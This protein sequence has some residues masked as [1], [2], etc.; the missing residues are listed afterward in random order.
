VIKFG[1]IKNFRIFTFQITFQITFILNHGI[2]ITR[3]FMMN[4][5]I[6]LSFAIYVIL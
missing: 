2:K 3:T 6:I 4:I 1:L 5:K